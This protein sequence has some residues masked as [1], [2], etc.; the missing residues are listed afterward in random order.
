M[1]IITKCL[2][3]TDKAKEVAQMYLKAM[4]KYPDNASVA[5]PTVPAAVHSTRQGM[6]VMVIYEPK[7]GKLEEAFAFVVNR[8][9]MFHDIQGFESTHEIHYNLEEAM[10]TIGM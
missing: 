1:Y 5:T 9:V 6:T 4:T 8:M 10:K 3:P 7:K 2:Y